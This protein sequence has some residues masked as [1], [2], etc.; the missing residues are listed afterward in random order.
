MGEHKTKDECETKDEDSDPL[1][2]WSSCWKI[3]EDDADGAGW[4]PQGNSSATAYTVWE[5]PQVN[6]GKTDHV[7]K[8]ICENIYENSKGKFLKKKSN[9]KAQIFDERRKE[10]ISEMIE[11][12]GSGLPIDDKTALK[13]KIFERDYQKERCVYDSN[14]GLWYANMG[15]F[16][17][18]HND[19]DSTK[20]YGMG[21]NV[22]WESGEG[23]GRLNKTSINKKLKDETDGKT[24]Q[25]TKAEIV[26]SG[27]KYHVA[28]SAISEDVTKAKFKISS[29]KLVLKDPGTGYLVNETLTFNAAE[30]TGVD[31]DIIITLT[32]KDIIKGER[33]G[34]QMKNVG[35]KNEIS[36]V[37][38]SGGEY[39]KNISATDDESYK[40]QMST[41]R[42]KDIQGEIQTCWGSDDP[43][44]VPSDAKSIEANVLDADETYKLIIQREG[45]TPQDISKCIRDVDQRACNNKFKKARINYWNDYTNNNSARALRSTESGSEAV[46]QARATASDVTPAERGVAGEEG[47]TTTI[48]SVYN[49][50]AFKE[51]GL[52]DNNYNKEESMEL[53]EEEEEKTPSLFEKIIPFTWF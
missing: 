3:L 14:K 52:L 21:V 34:H 29:G 41:L 20:F 45:Q 7:C 28:S 18:H 4:P 13:Q 36:E 16:S 2:S 46:A 26:P 35:G 49:E 30:I 44:A 32:E 24:L 47:Q 48:E 42:W 6:C 53:K 17:L 37:E 50:N 38:L 43:S 15:P 11:G 23:W 31:E 33:R 10:Q 25:L 39:L 40:R 27:G 12:E 51:S 1:P 19:T 22:L 9:L 5:S 8:E